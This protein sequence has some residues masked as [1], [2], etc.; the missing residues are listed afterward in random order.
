[1]TEQERTAIKQILQEQVR[2]HEANPQAARAFLLQTGIYTSSGEL[3]P[4]YGG[5]PE[6]P[7]QNSR[8]K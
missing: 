3:T 7:K 5:P 8:P 2:F 4:E 6:E 1:M